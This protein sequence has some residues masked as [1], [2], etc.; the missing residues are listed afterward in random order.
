[1]DTKMRFDMVEAPCPD[2]HLYCQDCAVRLFEESIRDESLFP[3]RC[4]RVS[5][6]LSAVIRLLGA[7]LTKRFEEKSVERND[8]YRTYC[9]NPVCSQ[10][11]LP[12]RVRSFIGTCSYCSERTCTL[13]KRT[14]HSGACADETDEVL[15]MARAEGWQRCSGCRNIVELTTG[16]NHIT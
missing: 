16:C 11:T 1:M 5:I 13:C 4:C 8:P 6:S 3:S 14:T 15:G 9:S 7:D 12:D 2:R 10:Y